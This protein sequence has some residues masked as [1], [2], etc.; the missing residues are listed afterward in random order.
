MFFDKDNDSRSDAPPG[1]HDAAQLVELCA[2]QIQ[3]A[4][5]EALAEIGELS[6]AV[7]DT[8]RH[9]GELLGQ[10]QGDSAEAGIPPAGSEPLRQAAAR[11]SSRLQFADRLSQRVSNVSSNLT[12][13]AT[14]M[15]SSDRPLT[16]ERWRGFLLEAR[17]RFT[18]E[19]ERLMFDAVFGTAPSG[20]DVAE[21]DASEDLIFFD[22][23]N[24]RGGRA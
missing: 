22:T 9:A 23:G 7:L 19:Q 15:K 21:D 6:V 1:G 2:D 3:S 10:V 18:M 5:T 20:Q 4:L 13:L 8:A 16:N 12:A 11:A 14:L 17:N 24:S